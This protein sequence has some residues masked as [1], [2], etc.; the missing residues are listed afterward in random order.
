MPL[1]DITK[2]QLKRVNPFQG[3]VIDADTW[4]DA[5]DYHRDQMRLHLLAFHDTGIV[6]GLEVTANNPPDLSLNIHTG[7]AIDPE[8]NCIIVPQTQR[9]QLQTRRKGVI[10]LVMQFR[11]VPAEPF[12]PPESGQPTRIVEAYRIQEREILPDEPYVELARIDFDPTKEAITDVKNLR[13]PG[14]N[15]LNLS[16]QKKARPVVSGKLEVAARET[17]ARSATVVSI[18]HVVLGGNGGDLHLEGWQH[19]IREISRQDKVEA[20][21]KENIAL[22]DKIGQ[23]SLIYVVGNGRFE[24]SAEQESALDYYMTSGGVVLGEGC[25]EGA[26]ED[27]SKGTREFGLAFN[28]LANRLKCKLETVQRGHSLLSAAHIFSDVPPGANPGMLLEGGHM[29][30]SGSDYGCAWKGGNQDQ[31]LP[32]DSIRSSLEMGANFIAYAQMLKTGGRNS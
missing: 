29:I 6:E 31:P 14:N 16:H 30:Y 13:S 15:E 4:R 9:Y 21:L 1:D 22:D 24:L 18:G 17:P 7:M 10:Y 19:L 3:L 8:G 11:E 20:I 25:A 5:H 23:Y 27:S 2:F 28:Q 32:R 12:Q 26:G